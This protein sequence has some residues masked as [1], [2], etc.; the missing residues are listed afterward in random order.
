M[1]EEVNKELEALKEAALEKLEK[2]VKE[3]APEVVKGAEA[4]L[5]KAEVV[6]DEALE[7]VAAVAETVPG[8]K[9]VVA[10]ADELVKEGVK[11][12]KKGLGALFT[13]GLVALVSGVR[14]ALHFVFVRIPV[15]AVS[16]LLR[17][18]PKKA[19]EKKPL[20]SVPPVVVKV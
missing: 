18:I 14:Y 15:G 12:A 13:K 10:V 9:E 6:V 5:N 2:E 20:S 8:G 16:P 17:L 1:S 7:K 11:E 19:E 4:A 3:I